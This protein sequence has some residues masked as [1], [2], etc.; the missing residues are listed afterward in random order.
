M[1][2]TSE[3]SKI[4]NL[5][6]EIYK[7]QHFYSFKYSVLVSKYGIICISFLE[8]EKISK[9]SFLWTHFVLY[10]WHTW[11]KFPKNWNLIYISFI[12]CSIL[13]CWRLRVWWNLCAPQ[14]G[15]GLRPSHTFPQFLFPI[16]NWSNF[17]FP[18]IKGNKTFN[19]SPIKEIKDNQTFSWS[20]VNN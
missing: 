6:E 14:F 7:S 19:W 8:L 11:Q 4:W 18:I 13:W 2:Y 3:S 12:L 10:P 20:Q 15:A 16:F 17:T 9:C 5:P 1:F